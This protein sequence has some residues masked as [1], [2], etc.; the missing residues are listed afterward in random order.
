MRERMLKIGTVLVYSVF[1]SNNN[2]TSYP[3]ISNFLLNY[4]TN[5]L[6]FGQV[7]VD[8]LKFMNILENDFF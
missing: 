8:K 6:I 4:P 1:D 5:S 3:L 2:N 7:T